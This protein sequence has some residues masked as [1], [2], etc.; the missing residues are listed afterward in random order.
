MGRGN[1]FTRPTRYYE[2]REYKPKRAKSEKDIFVTVATGL[3]ATHI[4]DAKEIAS[5]LN[6]TER[7]V[8]RW[9]ERDKWEE[10]LQTLKYEGKRNFRVKPRRS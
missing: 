3:F 8:H 6:T 7:I 10:V 1:S 9:V 5:P 4:R 2:R